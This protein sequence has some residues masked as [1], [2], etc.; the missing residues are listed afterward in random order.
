MGY[1]TMIEQSG[2]LGLHVGTGSPPPKL[3]MRFEVEDA[4]AAA[5]TNNKLAIPTI[6]FMQISSVELLGCLPC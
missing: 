3:T 1:F 6:L 5:R 2:L 4:P